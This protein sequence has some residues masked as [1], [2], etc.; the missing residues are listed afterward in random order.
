MT[1]K[2]VYLSFLLTKG[3]NKNVQLFSN[4]GQIL[5][6]AKVGGRQKT[7]HAES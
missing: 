7:V 6:R 2:L 4:L 5:Y 1:F 3:C